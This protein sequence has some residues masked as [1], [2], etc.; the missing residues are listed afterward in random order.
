MAVERGTNRK[1]P[2][3]YGPRRPGDPA[4]LI[5]LPDK[6]KRELGWVATRSDIDNIIRTALAWHQKDWDHAH[7]HAGHAAG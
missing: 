1:V 2:R 5:A 3:R 6:A 7:D 4:K